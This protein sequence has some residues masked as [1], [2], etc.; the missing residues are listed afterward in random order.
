MT[1]YVFPTSFMNM[2]KY[3]SANSVG[4]GNVKGHPTEDILNKHIK[5]KITTKNKR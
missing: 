4:K 1:A 2:M 3:M 5:A